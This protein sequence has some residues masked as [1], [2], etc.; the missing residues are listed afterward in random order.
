MIINYAKLLDTLHSNKKIDGLTHNYYKYPARFSPEFAKEIILEFT[1][2][3]DW[4]FDT[5]M[6]SGTT[7]VEALANGRYSLGIDINPLSH[8][9]T[10]VKTIPLRQQDEEKILKWA[11]DINF[12]LPIKKN[13]SILDDPRL[14]NLPNTIKNALLCASKSVDKLPL[15]RQ[16]N[17][18]RCALLGLGQWAIDCR[19]EIVPLVQWKYR[20]NN[21]VKEMIVGLN[22]LVERTGFHN[23]A[24]N[25]ITERRILYLG[26]VQNAFNDKNIQ[27]LNLRPKLVL[28][29]PPYPGVHI[30]YHR[31]QVESRRETPAPFWIA[32]LLD[33]NGESHYTMGSRTLFGLKNY[34][35][36]LTEIFSILRNVL[37][38]SSI[39]V[40]LAAFSDP[41]TQV[42]PFLNSMGNAGYMELT[43]FNTLRS[44]RPV[45][46]VP[47]R[48]WYAHSPKRQHSSYEFLFFHKPI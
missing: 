40:Q 36:K 6:G 41:D 28:T 9:I 21:Q 46:K 1:K 18:A 42:L 43:P 45:R 16:R 4:V 27:K 15:P 13:N 29:S 14:I 20:L 25:K 31:W 38:T 2:E 44:K 3:N 37:D 33:G 12:G 35:L 17:F 47:N 39:V 11:K 5:F 10:K 19:R 48:K 34:F 23:I 32:N 22:N 26:S 8:F 7:I 24:K 30:L